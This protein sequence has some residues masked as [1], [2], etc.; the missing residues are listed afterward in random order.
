MSKQNNIPFSFK[1]DLQICNHGCPVLIFISSMSFISDCNFIPKTEMS[2]IFIFYVILCSLYVISIVHKLP[3]QNLYANLIK[4]KSNVKC[5]KL[6]H[7]QSAMK[8]IKV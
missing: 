4:A 2:F 1:E 3:T 8:K 7:H 6:Q 5:A